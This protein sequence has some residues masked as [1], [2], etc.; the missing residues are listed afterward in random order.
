MKI[1]YIYTMT[2]IY[3]NWVTIVKFFYLG[4]KESLYGAKK[5]STCLWQHYNFLLFIYSSIDR[6]M[7][8][9]VRDNIMDLL[10]VKKY[11]QV[12]T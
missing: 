11:I 8:A 9:M 3:E 1:I 12:G 10:N 2:M 5:K 7:K 4:Y 6:T